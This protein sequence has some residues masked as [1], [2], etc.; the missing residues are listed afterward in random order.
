MT[1]STVLLNLLWTVLSVAA[2]AYILLFGR[3]VLW[4]SLG[5]V[6]LVATANL[7]AIFVP[8]AEQAR[9]LLLM[10]EWLLLGIAVLVGLAGVALGRT[11]PELA[12]LV[13]GFLAGADFGL[14][15]FEIA[16]Y[17][18]TVV[19]ELPETTALIAGVAIAILVGLGGVWLVRRFRD[20]ALIIITMLIGVELVFR[21]LR[22]DES[23][24]L[25]A[26][27]LLIICL[28]SLVVQ[29]ADYLRELKADTPLTQYISDRASRPS[30]EL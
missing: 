24:N 3:R 15:F 1:I 21:G 17:V 2:G 4:A 28:F 9:D 26:V 13:L 23:S 7:L 8:E 27:L 12:G 16:R 20:E 18:T 14:W 10:H 25:T 30:S 19:G 6:G 29:Y 5:I 22:L 11:R